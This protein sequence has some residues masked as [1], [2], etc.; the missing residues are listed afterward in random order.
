MDARAKC[1][2][3]D[4]WKQVTIHT[5]LSTIVGK[6]YSNLQFA[7]WLESGTTR[8]VYLFVEDESQQLSKR[9]GN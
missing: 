3:W 7:A 5:S 4:W 6:Y 1:K 9:R 8:Y 2:G